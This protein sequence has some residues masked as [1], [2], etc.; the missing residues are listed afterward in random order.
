MRIKRDEKRGK[1]GDIKRRKQ[2]DDFLKP[3]MFAVQNLFSL[4]Q[5]KKILYKNY[6][7]VQELKLYANCIQHRVY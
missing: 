3:K 5:S 4:L 7:K 1:T 2:R 6:R